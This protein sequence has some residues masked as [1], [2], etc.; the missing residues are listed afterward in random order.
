MKRMKLESH[1]TQYYLSE[2]RES[3][4]LENSCKY[5]VLHPDEE[6]IQRFVKHVRKTVCKPGTP[7]LVTLSDDG[8][9]R[10]DPTVR[11][12]F[13]HSVKCMYRSFAGALKP[14]ITILTNFSDWVEFED[15][16]EYIFDDQV[17]VQCYD[18][19]ETK[20]E[21][22]KAVYR[23]AFAHV[24][25]RVEKRFTDNSET[26]LSIDMIVL[27]STSLNM[28]RRHMPGTLRYW[29]NEM[30]ALHLE[31]YNKVAD[32]SMVNLVPVLAGK[33]YGNQSEEWPSE[34]PLNTVLSL[35]SVPFIWKEFEGK[36]IASL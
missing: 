14:Q 29:V 15:K 10:I 17:E 24:P 13:N 5:P 16:S 27:D 28:M 36:L 34:Y 22:K 3:H 23:F 6:S 19:N 12:E 4:P 26:L 35:E 32:N 20:Y 30:G 2:Y 18:V 9:L 21:D 25:R 33:R 7:D 11:E 31:G 1:A 8:Y